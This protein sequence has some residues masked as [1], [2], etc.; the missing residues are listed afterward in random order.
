MYAQ[1]LIAPAAFEA[2]EVLAPTP[3]ALPPRAVLL[4]TLAGGV[5]GS[6]LPHFMGRISATRD[7]D[8]STG[9]ARLPGFP[10]HEVVGEVVATS[11]TRHPAGTRV[12]GWADKMDAL[13]QFV[14]TSGDSVYPCGN[15]L[16]PE[17]AVMLQPL[18]CVLHTIARIPEVA[19]ARV[20]VLG[21]GPIGLL[22]SHAAKAAGAAEVVGVDRVDRSSIASSYG[23]DTFVHSSADR[24]ARGLASAERPTV[25]IEAVGHQPG[26]LQSAVEAISFGGTVF[27]FGVPDEPVYPFPIGGALRKNLTFRTGVVEP[28]ARRAALAAAVGYLQE[29]RALADSYVTSTFALDDCSSAYLAANSPRSGQLKIAVTMDRPDLYANASQ[30]PPPL[31]RRD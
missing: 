4:R 9:A 5:C 1:R 11:D 22:F 26:T 14:V 24:W 23:V 15:S 31:P 27:Y 25:L 2:C 28:A 10:M 17:H 13:A 6:D 8:V 30:G 3:D 18:A 16:A 19:G 7:D 29:H 21:L 20:A 12:V